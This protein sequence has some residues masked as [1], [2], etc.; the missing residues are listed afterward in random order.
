MGSRR[1]EDGTFRTWNTIQLGTHR[2]GIELFAAVK[3]MQ[4]ELAAQFARE[5]K[6]FIDEE[7]KRGVQIK[8]D[9]VPPDPAQERRNA[10]TDAFLRDLAS[11]LPVAA[12]PVSVELV[13]AS[14]ADLGLPDNTRL[15]AV[16]EAARRHGLYRCVPEAAFQ[17]RL[18]T[19]QGHR[20]GYYLL[21]SPFGGLRDVR[22]DL[23]GL[24]DVQLIDACFSQ[25][26]N[27]YGMAK[28]CVFL[29]QRTQN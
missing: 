5:A 7:I 8:V 27:V 25:P 16:E 22:F 17:A 12:S 23:L 29:W 14:V 6:E 28:Q 21:A 2:T 9:V 20:E 13:A 4:A 19:N 11:R 24:D 1:T 15:D 26:D 18:Q 10:E 3:K